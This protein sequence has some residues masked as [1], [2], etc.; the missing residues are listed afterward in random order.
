MSMVPERRSTKRTTP[1]ELS[2]IRFEPDGGG[3]VLNASEEGI[4]FQAATPVR[5]AGPVRLCVSPNPAHRIELAAE[6][7]WMDDAKKSGGLRLM[8]VPE[9]TLAQLRRWLMLASESRM[10]QPDFKPSERASIPAPVLSLPAREHV[11]LQPSPVVASPRVPVVR[12]SFKRKSVP[13]T[14]SVN[15]SALFPELSL[16]ARHDF[17]GHSRWLRGTATV[18]LIFVFAL[19]PLLF[20]ENFRS[21]FGNTL[22]RAGEKLKGA[23]AA[24]AEPE[25]VVPTSSAP[26]AQAAAPSLQDALPPLAPESRDD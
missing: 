2:Y 18:F 11:S 20:L 13:R 8:E 17:Y 7:A 15:P 26:A 19:I 1:E 5:Q 3:I 10:E 9:E 4:A 25:P 16:P 6:I 14:M 24:Q 21:E 23:V 12:A 22:I